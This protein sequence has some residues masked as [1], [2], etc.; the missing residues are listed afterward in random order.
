MDIKRAPHN[1]KILCPCPECRKDL[2]VSFWGCLFILTMLFAVEAMKQERP[3]VSYCT[4]YTVIDS[5]RVVS[6]QGDTIPFNYS[7][8][9]RDHDKD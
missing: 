2:K 1:F 3:K 8:Y 4:G 6:C 7:K 5:I 9:L